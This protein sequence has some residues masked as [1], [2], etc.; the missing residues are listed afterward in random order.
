MW[1]GCLTDIGDHHSGCSVLYFDHGSCAAAAAVAA[2]PA[3]FALLH[4]MH[5]IGCSQF[6]CYTSG[7]SPVWGASDRLIGQKLSDRLIVGW[8]MLGSVQPLQAQLHAAEQQH[9]D[10]S[11][12]LSEDILIRACCKD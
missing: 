9:A 11:K 8:W 6:G 3:L 4:G 12:L 7:T 1:C 5:E 10:R 2:M